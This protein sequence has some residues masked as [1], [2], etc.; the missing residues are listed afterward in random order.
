[1][2][3]KYVVLIV[4]SLLLAACGG[5]KA[6]P[7][8]SA[9]K[10]FQEGERFFESNLYEDAIAS[11]EKVRDTFYS[12]ELSMLAE[13]KIAET[14]YVS[15]RYAEAATAFAD[16]LKQHPNDFRAATIL[17][18]LGL[19]YYQQILSADRDQTHTEN[20]LRT[21]QELVQ[22]FP[23]DPNAQEAGYLIQRCKTRLAEHEVY[24]AAYYVKKK[25]YKP[26]IKRLEDVLATFP[27]YY[28]RDEAFFYLGK[29]YLKSGQNDKAQTI[30]QQLFDQFP[31]SDYVEDAQELLEDNS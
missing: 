16:F 3:K 4:V 12:P 28:Y 25:L 14:Y 22:R 15:E 21:F 29:A 13:L 5:G 7:E 1:M 2:V 10:Y 20:A 26:A 9:A 8:N 30:F 18:R 17:Y 23:N 19:S 24:I 6:K 31:G 27:D 11:W